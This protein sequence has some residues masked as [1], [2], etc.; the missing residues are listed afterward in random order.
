MC[1]WRSRCTFIYGCDVMQQA[2]VSLLVPSMERLC[3]RT[4]AYLQVA[5]AQLL[6]A[7][8]I[9]GGLRPTEVRLPSGCI[10]EE[11]ANYKGELVS[12]VLD[13]TMDGDRCCQMCRCDCHDPRSPEGGTE[14]FV[15]S[16]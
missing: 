2:S 3:R 13:N 12:P 14:E 15:V 5:Q 6:N 4:L 8:A 1:T 7:T 10:Q 9:N 11:D 16:G